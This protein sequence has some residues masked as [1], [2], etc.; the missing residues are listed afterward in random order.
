MTA[1]DEDVELCY[2]TEGPIWAYYGRRAIIRSSTKDE[3]LH[4]VSLYSRLAPRHELIEKEGRDDIHVLLVEAECGVDCVTEVGPW[5]IGPRV[6][7]EPQ[8]CRK[9]A[10][11]VAGTMPMPADPPAPVPLAVDDPVPVYLQLVLPVAA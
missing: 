4:A 2:P 11:F 3:P 7:D 5:Y 6:K 9:C 8:V 1:V 10:K